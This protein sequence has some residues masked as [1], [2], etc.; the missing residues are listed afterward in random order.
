MSVCLAH[1]CLLVKGCPI[2]GD[3]FKIGGVVE[4]RCGQCDFD[5]RM[6]PTISVADDDLGLF[7]Q[8]N[9]QSWLRI[10]T[11][12]RVDQ[13]KLP[14]QPDFTLYQIAY[15][16]HRAIRTIERWWDY[17]HDPFDIETA[18]SVF[19][20][21]K[22]SQMMPFKA[23]ILYVTAVK[24]L[25]RWMHGIFEFLNAF[26]LRDQAEPTKTVVNDLGSI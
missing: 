21:D 7:S 26:K 10:S 20:C 15:G 14:N 18:T 3:K 13:G 24:A 17:L 16:L 4:G 5:L 23:Y 8:Q 1:R 19:P 6:S 2:C 11:V 25:L 22:K 9:I 12:N